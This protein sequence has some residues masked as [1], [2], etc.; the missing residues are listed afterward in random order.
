MSNVIDLSERRAARR[1][2]SCQP[3]AGEVRVPPLNGSFCVTILFEGLDDPARALDRA[4]GIISSMPHGAARSQAELE[5][6][7]LRT[8]LDIA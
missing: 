4:S 7:R 6:T 8:Y 2:E 5:L 3:G 1:R